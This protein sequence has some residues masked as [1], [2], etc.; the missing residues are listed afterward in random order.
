MKRKH[1]V[2]KHVKPGL[3]PVRFN[4]SAP[5][6]KNGGVLYGTTV[7]KKKQGVRA[8][9]ENGKLLPRSEPPPQ[10]P[11]MNVPTVSRSMLPKKGNGGL[12]RGPQVSQDTS[13][14]VA[15]A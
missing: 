11:V 7:V 1:S 5:K 13:T 14:E 12:K 10:D 3:P 4:P 9:F 2:H 6:N 8:R 15:T